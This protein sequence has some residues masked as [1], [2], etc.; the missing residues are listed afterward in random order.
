MSADVH[1]E[2]ARCDR[3]ILEIQTRPDISTAPAWLLTLG[4]NDWECEKM[5]I[6][7]E[8]AEESRVYTDLRAPFPWF[9]GKS[10]VADIVWDRFGNVDNYVE[11]FAGS[12]AVLL[13]RPHAPQTETV[14][15]MDCYL[16]NFWRALAIDPEGLTLHADWPVNEADLHARHLWL[17]NQD[18][19]RERMKTEPD[20]F[21][22]RIAGWWVWGISQ[23]IGSG[24]CSRPD[25]MGRTNAAAQGRGI[26]RKQ[27]SRKRPMIHGGHTGKGIHQEDL[28]RRHMDVD[29][30]WNSRPI[31]SSAGE[32]IHRKVNR[33]LPSLGDSGRGVA[34]Q[35]P[36]LSAHQGINREGV[37]LKRPHLSGHGNGIGIHSGE[38]SSALLA[39]FD[40]LASRLRRVRVCCGDWKRVTGP[41]V[42]VKHGVC[43]I[44]LDPPYDM[45][46][47]GGPAPS[48][49]LYSTHSNDVSAE[50]RQWAI[51][52][53]D[54]PLLR[55]AL[56]GYEGEHSMPESWAC[57]PWKAHGGYGSQRG[58]K[59]NENAGRERIWF[60]P[61][62]LEEGP[63]FQLP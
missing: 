57:V 60:S 54:N 63:L 23:W 15:D 14:N 52:N 34:R 36:R 13:G 47:V 43:G 8:A 19:F 11:P 2:L 25:W 61:Y 62:C 24:W 40:E 20:Y 30:K 45:R 41:S 5:L 29:A 59:G 48:D 27:Q 38:R 22:V 9:G 39:Y 46:V 6:E 26:H 17:V 31:L 35:L 53:G 7:A 51:E 49:G 12:L 55:I 37:E 1:S 16:A 44:F 32:G 4:V 56:C 28:N 21:D 10:R 18:Q 42:T 33:K 3:E 58:G 50:V